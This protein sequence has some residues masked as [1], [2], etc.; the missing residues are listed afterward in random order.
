MR[1][2]L[3]IQDSKLS[4][5]LELIRNFR[6]IKVEVLD[7]EPSKEEIKSNIRKGVKELQLIEKGKLK[8]TPLKDFLNGL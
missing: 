4:F 6:F 8:T 1:L 7:K 2:V 3:S 5:F